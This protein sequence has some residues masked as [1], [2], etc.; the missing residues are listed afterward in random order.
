MHPPPPGYGVADLAVL[1]GSGAVTGADGNSEPISG[2]AVFWMQGEEHETTSV[3][4][5]TALLLEADGLMTF[6]PPT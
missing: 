1:E 6:R 4:G 5:M 2:E 3:G